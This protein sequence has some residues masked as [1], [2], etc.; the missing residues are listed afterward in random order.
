V[1]GEFLVCRDGPVF[2]I[3]QLKAVKDEF[4]GWKRDFNGRRIPV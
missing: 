3:N 2:N 4:G 1:I